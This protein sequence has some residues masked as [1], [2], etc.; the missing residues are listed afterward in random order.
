MKPIW[1]EYTEDKDAEQVAQLLCS[2][3][4]NL[5]DPRVLGYPSTVALKATDGTR[6]LVFMP[7]QQCQVWESLGISKEAS[8]L[9]VAASLKALAHVL[10]FKALENGQGEIYFLCSEPRTQKFAQHHGFEKVDIPLFR[11]RLR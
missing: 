8:E 11:M 2:T 1:A 3:S 10:R 6:N 9:E 7:V 5:F 4:Q